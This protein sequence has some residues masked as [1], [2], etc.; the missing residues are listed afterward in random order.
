MLILLTLIL[1]L[2]LITAVYIQ[3]PQ[4]GKHP[5]G[6]RLALIEKSPHYKDGRFRN[7]VE[8]PTISEG[9]SMMGEIYKTL[10][11]SYPSRHP[12]DSLPSVKTELSQLPPD[13]NLAVWMGHSTIYLQVNGKRILVDPVFS[14]KAS[15]LPWGVKAF[16][17]SNI[18]S[19]DDM[20]EIDYLI[21]SHDH[22]DHLDYE[23]ILQLK[24]K[25]K[26]VICG[27][28]V[29]AHFEY[30]GYDPSRIIEKDWYQKVEIDTNFVIHTEPTHHDS[31]RGFA[32]GRTL[33][34][35][36]LIQTPDMK[37]YVSGDGGYDSRFA[38]IGKKYGPIDWAI[39]EDGQYDK[40]WQSVHNLPE[41]VSQ[42][43][44]DLQ[45][46]NV[47]PVHHSKF[48]LGKHPWTEPLERIT[49][50]S[51]GK[52]Y[53]LQT[54]MIGQPVILTDSTQSFQQWWKGIN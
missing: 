12:V 1:V 42:A 24:P 37:I 36:Y 15:P 40:A 23:S 26:Q 52:S 49:A 28:G 7:R 25:V 43:A 31:G 51:A 54:P 50:L 53:K 30:W 9:Y 5:E 48:T 22:Y 14:G 19:A 17:G 4:F 34:M 16:K 35:S 45:A 27:L 46:K 33:W 47:I 8:R 18:Y 21:I 6:A 3:Q 32:R 13:S 41:D 38:E 10:F 11:K 39:I 20:P 29:G 2:A 44:I